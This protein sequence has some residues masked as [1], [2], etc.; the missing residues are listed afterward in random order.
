MVAN[1]VIANADVRNL[2]I[3]IAV[4]F[5]S[6]AILLKLA[7]IITTTSKL[8]LMLVLFLILLGHNLVGHATSWMQIKVL[9]REESLVISLHKML[10]LLMLL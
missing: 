2:A 7:E 1:V 3:L 4:N 5:I 6:I 9:H 8:L 10:L